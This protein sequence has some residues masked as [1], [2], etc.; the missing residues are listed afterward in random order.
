M[1][2]YLT[3]CAEQKV[4]NFNLK[5]L[6]LKTVAFSSIRMLR[7]RRKTVLAVGGMI[8]KMVN[9]D[10]KKW[11]FPG[12]CQTAFLAF[13]T[14]ALRTECFFSPLSHVGNIHSKNSTLGIFHTLY[15]V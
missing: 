14:D 12:N 13:E 6:T 2:N 11:A 8:P 10:C 3:V 7:K 15:H 5:I 9:Y 1:S 4:F